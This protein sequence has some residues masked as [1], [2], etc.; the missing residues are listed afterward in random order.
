MG[1]EKG[2]VR[3]PYIPYTGARTGKPGDRAAGV[4]LSPRSAVSAPCRGPQ[5]RVT[6]DRKESFCS[7]QWW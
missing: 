4:L 2:R 5:T 1:R 6:R 3:P 7:I